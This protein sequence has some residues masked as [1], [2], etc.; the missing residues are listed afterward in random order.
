MPIR[1]SLII[2]LGIA[3]A[4]TPFTVMAHKIKVFATAQGDTITGYAYL[5]GGVRVKDAA[6]RIMAADDTLLGE[7]VTDSSGSFLFQTKDPLDHRIIVDAGGGHVAEFTV[8][9]SELT[10]LTP[11][12]TA[13]PA[14][15]VD[16][17]PPSRSE[18]ITLSTTGLQAVMDKAVARQ[19]RPLREQLD[20]Y[21]AELRWRDVLGGIGYIIGIAG[22]AFYFLGRRQQ[23]PST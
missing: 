22:V 20:A 23:L 18:E 14:V 12:S 15:P 7:T 17:K 10:G 9:A 19:L 1:L 6:V 3:S 16:D 5:S 11:S 21:Q 13:S 4:A 2:L 8:K